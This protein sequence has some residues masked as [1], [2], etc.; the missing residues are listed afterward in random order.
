MDGDRLWFGNNYYDGEGS[1][2]VGAFGYF[3]LN[4]RR[5]L[6]FSPPEIAHWEI[7][8]LLVEP[9]AVWL[10]LD[11][12]GEN[13]SKFPGGLARWD[14]NHHRIRHYTLEFVVDRIQRE[15]RDA[16]LLRLT[17]HSGYAL[18]RD[19][20]LRRFRVQKG[21]GGKEVVVPIARFPPLPTNQ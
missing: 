8:A 13:I 12:F 9:D 6:L 15:K 21:S 11:H 7:S 5:Y 19:G 3:D 16:S 4:A 10:G 2:G 1:T 14:R 17:T 18:F 20:E